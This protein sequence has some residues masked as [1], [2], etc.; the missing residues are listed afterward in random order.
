MSNNVKLS[1]LVS[2]IKENDLVLPD[3]QRNF[4]WNEE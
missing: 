2:K 3:F 4:V 1:E